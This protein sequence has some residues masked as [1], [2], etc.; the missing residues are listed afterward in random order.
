VI[1]CDGADRRADQAC[2]DREILLNLAGT[3]DVVVDD[4][5]LPINPPDA[6]HP[7]RG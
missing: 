6:D 3:L 4:P 1:S 2:I 7:V 5:V